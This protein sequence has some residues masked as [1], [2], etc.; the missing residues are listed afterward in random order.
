M[1]PN[2]SHLSIS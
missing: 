1:F 2:A